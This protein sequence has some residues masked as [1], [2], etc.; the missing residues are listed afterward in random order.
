MGGG[1]GGGGGTQYVQAS[2]PMAAPARTGEETQYLAEQK[3]QMDN[4][5]SAYESQLAALNKQY[6]DAQQ[7][8]KSVL[9]Q[10]QASSEAQRA[11]ADQNK[12]DMAAASESSQKQLS[13]LA[14][15]RDQAVGISREAQNS[16]LNQAGEMYDRLT[17]RRQAR[18]TAY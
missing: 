5:K 13:L 11:T 7:Q 3:T 2:S 10:L 16:Q 8:S 15:S 9:A 4:M 1:K 17:R 14:A 12:A 6:A 18:R